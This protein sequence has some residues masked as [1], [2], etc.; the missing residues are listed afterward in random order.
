MDAA[1][2]AAVRARASNTCEYCQRRQ[3]TSLL[4]PLQIEHVV[5]RKHHGS[6]DLDNLALAC[7]ECNLHKGSDLTGIDPD[8]G[9]VIPLFNPRRDRWD[10]HFAWDE[11]RIVGRSPVGRTR[12]GLLQLNS[13]ARLRVRRATRID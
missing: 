12:V 6:D 11:L 5:S 4:I 7:A 2:R 10:E 3:A 9:Q 8:T 13:P 1:T